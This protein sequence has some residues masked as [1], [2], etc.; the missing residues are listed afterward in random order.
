GGGGGGGLLAGSPRRV[1]RSAIRTIR[2][3]GARSAATS[4]VHAAPARSTSTATADLREPRLTE[5]A[6]KR[7]IVRCVAIFSYL[8]FFGFL[9]AGA[10]A[11]FRR[12]ADLSGMQPFWGAVLGAILGFVVAVIVF[13][14]LFLLLD[15]ADNPRR[16]REL[17]ERRPSQ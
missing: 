3:P 4:P 12:V 5:P 9:I 1:R 16:T 13:G 8:G 7:V 17:L 10:C 2:N 6:M 14:G 11:R 15:I